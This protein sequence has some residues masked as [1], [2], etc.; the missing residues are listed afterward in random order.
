MDLRWYDI[1]KEDGTPSADY[2][3]E[4]RRR[5]AEA[6]RSDAD[7]LRT[8][9]GEVLAREM[10]AA[11]LGCSPQEVP[12]Q[13]DE[14]GKP[15]VSGTGLFVS[16]SHS[17]AFVV[18]AVDDHPIGVDVETIRDVD[19]KFM[20]RVC[21]EEELS[22]VLRG[23][24]RER[25]FWE[26]WTAKEAVFKLTGHGPLLRLSKLALPDNVT[27]CYTEQFGCAMTVARGETS[28]EWED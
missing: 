27:V 7:R 17:G 16:V 24:D 26:L 15:V 22:Y 6:M 4:E 8:V 12:L 19:D 18:C 9:A 14:D 1:L 25:R 20:R 10:L 21:S 3:S 5:R 13:Y 11:R 28:N 2:L 23:N